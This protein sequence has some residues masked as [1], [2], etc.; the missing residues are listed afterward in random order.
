MIDFK[1]ESEFKQDNCSDI[2]I[3]NEQEKEDTNKNKYKEWIDGQFS[4]WDVR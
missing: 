4:V 1:L 3:I 2:E